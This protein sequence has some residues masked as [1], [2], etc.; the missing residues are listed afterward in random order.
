MD[1]RQEVNENRERELVA[2][3]GQ[4]L[5]YRFHFLDHRNHFIRSKNVGLENDNAARE[6]AKEFFKKRSS[7]AIEVWSEDR[8]ICRMSDDG[9]QCVAG[10]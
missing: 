8:F 9:L 1:P 6:R 4:T 7:D 3:S 5:S 2:I 10:H